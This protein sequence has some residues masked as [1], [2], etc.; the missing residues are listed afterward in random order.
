MNKKYP[1]Q[2]QEI[3]T[4]MRIDIP[5]RGKIKQLKQIEKNK[6]K[7]TILCKIDLSC[8]YGYYLGII[9]TYR[10]LNIINDK[11]ETNIQHELIDLYFKELRKLKE[12]TR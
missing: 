8:G 7:C 9:Q 12:K 5:S 4:Q 3:I 1:Q 10:R 11:E 2:I 6:E